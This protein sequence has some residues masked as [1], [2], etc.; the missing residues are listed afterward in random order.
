M[1]Q[2]MRYDRI[3]G[4]VARF[5]DRS[6]NTDVRQR[7]S[8]RRDSTHDNGG[9]SIGAGANRAIIPSHTYAG[10]AHAVCQHVQ[11]VVRVALVIAGFRII[12][13]LAVRR[14]LKLPLSR[15]QRAR[16]LSGD[17]R[18]KPTTSCVSLMTQ[19]RRAI[20]APA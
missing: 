9:S 15:Q 4:N 2:R 20:P 11:S 16:A 14:D 19:V 10:W 18:L 3:F 17:S 5:C 8:S 12:E 13:H 7:K 1:Q 6:G